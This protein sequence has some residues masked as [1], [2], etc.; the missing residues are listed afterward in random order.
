MLL[1]YV[2]KARFST[3]SIISNLFWAFKSDMEEREVPVYMV[4]RGHK[5]GQLNVFKATLPFI[6]T[7]EG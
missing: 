5:N 4:S 2:F 7:T 6:I 3:V 1:S